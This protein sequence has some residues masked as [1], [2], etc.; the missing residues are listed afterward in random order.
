MNRPHSAQ[1]EPAT[2]AHDAPKRTANITINISA[3]SLIAGLVLLLIVGL[4]AGALVAVRVGAEPTLQEKLR[5][6]AEVASPQMLS[7]AFGQATRAVEASVVHITT[8][9]VD[10]DGSVYNQNSGSGVVVDPSGYI[11]TNYHVVKDSSKIKV[12]LMD[13]ST[14]SGQVVGADE[15]TD[16]AVVKVVSNKPLVAAKIG[17]SDNLNVG[18]WV[19]AIGSPFGLERSVTAGIISARERVTDENRSFQQLL[20]TDAAINPG[21]SGGPLVNMT[22]EVVGINSQIATRKGSFEGIGF[23]V[24]STI[25][26]DVYNQLLEKG[27]VSRGYLGVVPAK[28]T[29][30]FAQVYNLPEVS[31]ALIH[32][33]SEENGPA[34]KVGLKSGDVIVEFDNHKIKDDRDLVRRIVTTRVNKNVPLKYYRNGQINTT[35][36]SLVERPGAAATT[37]TPRPALDLK[38]RMG[39]DDKATDKLGLNI[40]PLTEMRSKQMAYPY[41]TTTGVVVRTINPDHVAYDAGLRDNDVIKEINKQPIT[42]PEDF[43]QA[44]NKLKSGDSVVLFVEHPTRRGQSQHKFIS[45][46]VP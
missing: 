12:R 4:G 45:L 8:V 28:V 6:S 15:D 27:R 20:Q 42:K 3:T 38:P 13:S 30:Q 41:K 23:A 9:D 44:I 18:D 33:L 32:E 26:I 2:S 16:L 14:L 22:G 11:L 5:M 21:N 10:T 34:A 19:L 46:T 36:V 24:P 7:A 17:D 1:D 29:A 37:F 31:G 35:M 40:A 43:T 25:F 39:K